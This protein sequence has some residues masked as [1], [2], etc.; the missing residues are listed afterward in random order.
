MAKRFV[1]ASNGTAR[2]VKRWCIAVN[3]QAREIKRACIAVNGVV[4]EF[5]TSGGIVWPTTEFLR[6]LS[7]TSPGD[8]VSLSVTS[9]ANGTASYFDST[10]Q[11]DLPVGTWAD[12]APANPA[13]YEVRLSD[14]SPAP[15]LG[16]AVG[17]WHTANITREWYWGKGAASTIQFNWSYRRTGVSSSEVV[18]PIKFNILFSP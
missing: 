4:R 7:P 17:V 1:I 9:R 13:D 14:S 6:V 2:E 12:P 16:P 8:G 18:R 10:D 11:T 15:A 3:G 5:Y